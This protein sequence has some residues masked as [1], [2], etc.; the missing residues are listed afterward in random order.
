[1]LYHAIK[2]LS[3]GLLVAHNHPSGN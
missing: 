2:N 3:V 1:M